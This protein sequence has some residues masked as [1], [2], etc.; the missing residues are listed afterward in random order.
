MRR[1]DRAVQVE[2]RTQ[3]FIKEVSETVQ[4]TCKQRV[5]LATEF[6]KNKII[7][8]ISRPVTKTVVRGKQGR[9]AQG[10]FT[11]RKSRTVVSDRSKPGEFPR[12]DTT[13]LLKTIFSAYE[14]PGI[15]NYA[16]FVGTPL[17]YGLR[18][19]VVEQLDRSFLVRTLNEERSNVMAIL[20]GP[21]K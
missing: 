21:I 13:Q 17:D 4:L 3:W 1:T 2:I 10:K 16:G 11:A 8:N 7:R 20:S 12:A 6:V 19:E 5:R 18:L 9:D 15:G 14:E